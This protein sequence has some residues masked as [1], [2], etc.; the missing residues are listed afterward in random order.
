[1]HNEEDYNFNPSPNEIKN[2]E[3]IG[4]VARMSELRNAYKVLFE[5]PERKCVCVCVCVCVCM[6]ACTYVRTYDGVSKSERE[7]QMV[8]LSATRCSC[9]AIL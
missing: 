4:N 2:S 3:M 1:M 7:L 6:Y 9:I 5:E 8:E